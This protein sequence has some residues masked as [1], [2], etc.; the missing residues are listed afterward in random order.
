MAVRK[1]KK[2]KAKAKSKAASKKA[3]KLKSKK[4]AKTAAAIVQATTHFANA[5]ILAARRDVITRYLRAYREVVDWMYTDDAAMWKAFVDVTTFGEPLWR[6]T[7]DEFYP[8]SSI[9]PDTMSGLDGVMADGIA[10]KL[11]SAPLTKEQLAEL[12]IQLPK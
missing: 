9:H 6:Q 4:P 2:S 11:M 12:I 8:K 5:Q 7:R 1:A 3:V 10:Y